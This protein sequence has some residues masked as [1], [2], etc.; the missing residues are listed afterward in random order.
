MTAS[1]AEVMEEAQRWLSQPT[2][3]QRMQ[4][5]TPVHAGELSRRVAGV[6]RWLGGILG[7]TYRQDLDQSES[8]RPS[9]M[10]AVEDVTYGD[11]L[12]DAHPGMVVLLVPSWNPSGNRYR[13]LR[14]PP[15]P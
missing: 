1:C 4:K 6:R 12:R 8:V 10:H 15:P 14:I 5:S 11:L 9:S 13:P 2:S 3:K 7:S